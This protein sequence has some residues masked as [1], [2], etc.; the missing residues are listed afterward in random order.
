MRSRFAR[1]TFV[2]RVWARRLHARRAC[3]APCASLPALPPLFSPSL[4]PCRRVCLFAS[5]RTARK[6]A[7]GLRSHK[8]PALRPRL[9]VPREFTALISQAAHVL[10]ASALRYVRS[11]SVGLRLRAPRA[12]PQIRMVG[13]S[14]ARSVQIWPRLR[15]RL[16][17]A[18]CRPQNKIVSPPSN[19]M[20]LLKLC[21]Y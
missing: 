12:V 4:P 11:A 1:R 15:M 2:R 3:E 8:S 20:K 7:R 13:G 21:G 14:L 9:V 17:R 19:P 16:C 18:A 10:S 6:L 5:G